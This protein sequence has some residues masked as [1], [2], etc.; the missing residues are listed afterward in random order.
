ML[1]ERGGVWQIDL[2]HPAGGRVRVSTGCRTDQ[3]ALAE[4][5]HKEAEIAL[6]RGATADAV[7][8]MLRVAAITT[9]P[10]TTR[11]KPMRLHHRPTSER[12]SGGVG[13]TLGELFTR[14]LPILYTEHKSLRSVEGNFKILTAHFGESCDLRDIDTGA[15]DEFITACREKRW[16]ENGA[17]RKL[18][19]KTINRYNAV[20]SKLLT[21]AHQRGF[22]TDVPKI[23]R[24]EESKGRIRY[25]LPEEEQKVLA[26]F[27]A[28]DHP[29]DAIMLDLVAVLLDA[30]LR[31]SEAYAMRD[32]DVNLRASPATLAVWMNKA[33]HPRT[34]P[35]TAR[36]RAILTRRMGTGYPFGDLS[37]L[38]TKPGLAV[39]RAND[40][41]ER[42]RKAI[43]LAHDKEFV[44]HA[45]RHTTCTRLV[46]GGVDLRRVQKYMGHLSI[47]TTL[48]YEHMAPESLN[49]TE[50]VL[51]SFQE[52]AA[53]T[54]PRSDCADQSA[55]AL[56]AVVT[57]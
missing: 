33:D 27:A 46:Q 9:G 26:A 3:R 30:G 37:E 40:R 5:R 10:D 2:A 22:I 38:G 4:V 19:G 12:Q 31:H 16:T 6:L 52:Q 24:Q 29:L 45:L 39:D 17:Q 48:K 34:V 18:S 36:A 57:H 11:S 55:S 25:L 13:I 42:M 15:V 49:G 1:K 54:V 50:R 23:T 28:S 32:M 20:L 44:M 14:A 7:R 35:L 56:D 41:W 47:N 53:H 8:D 43:G 21:F 51:E